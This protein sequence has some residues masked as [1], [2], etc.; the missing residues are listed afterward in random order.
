MSKS[1]NNRDKDDGKDPSIGVNPSSYILKLFEQL[2]A[3]NF[4]NE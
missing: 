2:K 1:D 4:I 3:T